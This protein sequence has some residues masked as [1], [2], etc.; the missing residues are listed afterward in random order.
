MAGGP[1]QGSHAG[2]RWQVLQEAET[3]APG[4]SSA[5]VASDVGASLLVSDGTHSVR[6]LVTREALEASD[7]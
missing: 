7:W 6:C 2:R 1:G 4:P 5:P 3:D